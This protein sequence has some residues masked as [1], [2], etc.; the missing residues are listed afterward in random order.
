MKL[1]LLLTWL[2]LALPGIL[3]QGDFAALD[4][5]VAAVAE[6]PQFDPYDDKPRGVGADA[7]YAPKARTVDSFD[8]DPSE[9]LTFYVAGESSECFYQ[10]AKF[11]GDDLGG[12]YVV[13][14]AD[15][16]IDLEVKNPEGVTIYR[17]LGDA[18]GQYIVTPKQSGV[19]ELCFINPD[20]DG[21]LVTHVTNTLQ[22]Q[23]P[24]EKE[25][26]SVLA[27]YA[28]H[29]DVRLGELES[30]QRL[31]L[32]RTDRHIKVEEEMNKHVMF[33]GALECAVYLVVCFFQ[34][35]YIK[36]LLDSPRKARSW[37]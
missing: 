37:V 12:A 8:F 19:H 31:Q 29:L 33:Y 9:G 18:E 15:S 5:E 7:E 32:I 1:K 26:V 16:H 22:S 35:Y 17:R 34:V 10:D 27:K 28:S 13:S 25:H 24:V 2:V 3:A 21:K 20:S 30:E 36:G 14:S 4:P 23:H 11:E 6:D